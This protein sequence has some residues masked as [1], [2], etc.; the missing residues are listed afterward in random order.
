MQ[1]GPTGNISQHSKSLIWKPTANIIIKDEKL[2]TFPLKS[3]KRQGCSLSLLL[4]NIVLGALATVIREY[5]EITDIQIGKEE[6]KL[7]L[8]ADNMIL[9]TETLKAS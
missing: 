7:S 5:K 3:G 8:Y 6:V 9:Y 2:R 4:L 1:S